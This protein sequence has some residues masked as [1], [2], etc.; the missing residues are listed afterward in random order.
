MTRP[1]GTVTN[2]DYAMN[3]RS[4]LKAFAAF[5]PAAWVSQATA[6]P[7]KPAGET[8]VIDCYEW[9]TNPKYRGCRLLLDGRDITDNTFRSCPAQGWADVYESDGK[10]DVL[11]PDGLPVEKR[12]YGRVEIYRKTERNGFA[13]YVKADSDK[14][15]AVRQVSNSTTYRSRNWSA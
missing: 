15:D 7:V 10:K 11:G 9:L 1:A 6:A 8:D 4:F 3:R 2:L 13:H 5:V 12:L 14:A